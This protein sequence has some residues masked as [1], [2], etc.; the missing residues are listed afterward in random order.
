MSSSSEHLNDFLPVCTWSP[1][2]SLDIAS[3]FLLV[4][5]LSPIC[6]SDI[7][8]DFL[9]FCIQSPIWGQNTPSCTTHIPPGQHRNPLNGAPPQSISGRFASY[10]NAFL[11]MFAVIV[12]RNAKQRKTTS[13][14]ATA[15]KPPERRTPTVNKRA[16]CII[17][18]CFLVY[19]CS[20]S[21]PQR[22]TA[23]NHIV[24]SDSNTERGDYQTC[25]TK[26]HELTLQL[27]QRLRQT[28]A[29]ADNYRV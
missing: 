4:H 1:I 27:Q 16:V 8:T 29:R 13:S 18:E 5:T 22:K 26:N 2:C 20:D 9:S 12:P 10:W 7:F 14:T 6:S 24:N 3:D 15:Q 19:V 17:L 25:N 23:Q 21:T 11:F 28:A